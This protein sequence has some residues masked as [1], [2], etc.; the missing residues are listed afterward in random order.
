VKAQDLMNASTPQALTDLIHQDYMN[1]LSKESVL[2]AVTLYKEAVWLKDNLIT[3]QAY[4]RMTRIMGDGRQFSN[5]Q[6]RTVPYA[7]C[8]EMT[9]VR[10][11]RAKA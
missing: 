6:I 11:A 8:V 3:E 9:F 4:D 2:K 10:K 1:A 5:E 7:Q